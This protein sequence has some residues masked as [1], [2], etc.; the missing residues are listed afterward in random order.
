MNASYQA[1]SNSIHWTWNAIGERWEVWEKAYWENLGRIE[2]GNGEQINH[3]L[4]THMKFS[5]IKIEELK[6]KNNGSLNN[7]LYSHR[8]ERKNV[9]VK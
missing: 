1:H 9:S 8:I 3:I 5:K 6:F 4:Q 2:G 7:V